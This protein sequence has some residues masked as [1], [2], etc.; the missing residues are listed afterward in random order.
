MGTRG[1]GLVSAAAGVE[2]VFQKGIFATSANVP[3]IASVP[4]MLSAP[5]TASVPGIEP[6]RRVTRGYPCSRRVLR[7]VP[8]GQKM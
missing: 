1:A 4:G 5:G 3:K 6:A 2:K 8:P 7:D